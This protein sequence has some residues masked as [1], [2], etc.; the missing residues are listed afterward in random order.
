M[1][2]ENKDGLPTADGGFDTDISREG[3][4]SLPKE[5]L[6]N[7]NTERLNADG[8]NVNAADAGESADAGE[9][10]EKLEY[11]TM[12]GSW[13]SYEAEQ[14]KQSDT[15]N[16]VYPDSEG[17]NGGRLDGG[18]YFGAYN[19]GNGNFYG[20]NSWQT[21]SGGSAPQPKRNGR[22]IALLCAL[23]AL[24]LAFVISVAIGVYQLFDRVMDSLGSTLPPTSEQGGGAGGQTP[25][26]SSSTG[27]SASSEGLKSDEA[28]FV[29][30]DFK[31]TQNE[32]GTVFDRTGVCEKAKSSVVYIT[33]SIGSGSGV[34]IY[35]DERK[36][37]EG[38]YIVTNNHVIEGASDISVTVGE[39]KNCTA[40]FIGRDANSDLAVLKISETEELN[41]AE[42]GISKNLKTGNDVIVIGNPLGL[43]GSATDGIISGD[44]REV[45]IDGYKMKLLQTS[46]AV[47]PGN[48][49]G[50]MF[51]MSGQLVGV[52]NAKYTSEEVEGI[53]FAIP[54]DSAKPIIEDL[55]KYGYVTG[56]S[57]LGLKVSY[58]V[59]IYDTFY[60][61]WWVTEVSR[62][63]DADAAEIKVNDQIVSV[64]IN[65]EKFTEGN[66]SVYLND[67]KPED[68]V[69]I[70]VKRYTAVGYRVYTSKEITFD[71][72]VSEYK[73]K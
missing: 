37:K 11:G 26:G 68:K 57:N 1:E 20:Q 62:G 33:S 2:E 65:G 15:E 56:R 29:G 39:K 47:N 64:L 48:S 43:T 70:T 42:I 40:I 53:G 16:G 22:K 49:G 58:G 63:A 21:P 67:L 34:I 6:Y 13:A 32:A 73:G 30:E 41:V 61:H 51:N 5:T 38:Y 52:I 31:L 72:T 46:A 27:A 45:T 10:P 59:S 25:N 66:L 7:E 12:P 17:T 3:S 4:E 54:I 24:A 28:H 35:K 71:I 23:G 18:S 8:I 50:G 14:K 36:G 19:G 55:M 69:V 9:A 60:Y 44:N